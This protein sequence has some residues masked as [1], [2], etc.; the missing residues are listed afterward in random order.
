MNQVIFCFKELTI[1]CTLKNDF[2]QIQRCGIPIW[3]GNHLEL[4]ELLESI[5]I[6]K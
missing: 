3:A 1:I 5:H 4:I 2:C 6:T